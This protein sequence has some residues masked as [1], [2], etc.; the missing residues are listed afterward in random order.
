MHAEQLQRSKISNLELYNE[1]SEQA[2]YNNHHHYKY[3]ADIDKNK[4][5]REFSNYSRNLAEKICI[6]NEFTSDLSENKNMKANHAH[7]EMNS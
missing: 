3:G 1:Y 5:K 4:Y 6:S 7:I 2:N